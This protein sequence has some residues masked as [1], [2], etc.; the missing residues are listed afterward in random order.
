LLDAWPDGRVKLYIT[1]RLLHLRRAHAATFLD[2][3]YRALEVSGAAASSIAAFAR[4]AI[5]FAVPRLARRHVHDGLHLSY[6]DE[7]IAVGR[8]G[9]T[10]RN[11]FD[12]RSVS[13]DA[14]GEITAKAAF[15]VAPLAVLVAG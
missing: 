13:A 1:W 9:G 6:D 2:G 12:G 10:Y 11:I 7:R 4:D 15:A 5:V 3:A 14:A 8:P